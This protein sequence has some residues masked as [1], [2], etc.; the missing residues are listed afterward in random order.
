MSDKG[1]L[2][3]KYKETCYLKL[4]QTTQLKMVKKIGHFTKEDTDVE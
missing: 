4:R 1:L 2:S 3:G